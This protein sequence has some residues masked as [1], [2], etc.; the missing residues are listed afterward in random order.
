VSGDGAPLLRVALVAS[1]VAVGGLERLLVDL[2]DCLPGRGID[3]VLLI[4]SG[5]EHRFSRLV[6]DRGLRPERLRGAP[7]RRRVATLGADVIHAFGFRSELAARA[8]WRRAGRP[9]LVSTVANPDLTRP[10]AWR[11]LNRL[12]GRRVGAFWADSEARGRAGTERLGV[13]ESRLRVI[14]PGIGRPL[15]ADAVAARRELG[16]GPA[17]PLVAVVGNLRRVKGHHLAVAAAPRVAEQVPAVSFV[18]LGEDLSGGEIPAL[19]RRSPEERLWWLGFV[20]DPGPWLAAADLLLQPSL[21][22]G[23]PRAV[24]EAMAVG[25]P[26]VATAVGGLPEVVEDGVT[27]VLVETGD[28]EGLVEA[29]VDLLADAQRRRMMGEAGRRRVRER[30][31]VERTVEELARL[32]REVGMPPAGRSPAG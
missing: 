26:V 13:P 18:F 7:L 2:G 8:A 9:G 23:L 31:G 21:S 5:A 1:S 20:E 28:V 16:L 19:M 14:R 24:L 17:D 22:E 3:P 25:T 15:D 29:V 4:A 12:T 32:Y 27:G 30:F 10:W 6:G 11:V